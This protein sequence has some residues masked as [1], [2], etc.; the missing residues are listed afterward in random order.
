MSTGGERKGETGREN[1]GGIP[2]GAEDRDPRS[3]CG[4]LLDVRYPSAAS[5]FP[6]ARRHR[7]HIDIDRG[8]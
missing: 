7:R 3:V 1:Q 2:L 4:Y 5:L 8:M 6:D